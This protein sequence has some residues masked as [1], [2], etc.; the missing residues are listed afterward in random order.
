MRAGDLNSVG[1]VPTA[2]PSVPFRRQRP[3]MFVIHRNPAGDYLL[4]RLFAFDCKAQW[5]STLLFAIKLKNPSIIDGRAVRR[6]F[7]TGIIW[8]TLLIRLS[9]RD[10]LNLFQWRPIRLV[11]KYFKQKGEN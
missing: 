4:R 10:A 2:E 9:K 8:L 5:L 7:R 3:K 11:N 1:N 6:I